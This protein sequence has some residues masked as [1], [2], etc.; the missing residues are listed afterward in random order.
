PDTV[1][2]PDIAVYGDAE[3]FDDIAPKYAETPP[4]L[5]VEILSPHDK[6]SLVTMKITDYL[7]S[8][9]VLVW[10]INPE[11]R[12]VTVY[13]RDN[14]PQVFGEKDTLT[15]GD[16]LPG[17]KIKVADLFRLPSDKLPP[18]RKRKRRP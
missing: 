9:V 11:A 13:T 8:G 5:I 7:R 14:G 16:I 1:R 18:A 3:H 15:G 17:L 2:G 6:A 12:E 4:L 10:L